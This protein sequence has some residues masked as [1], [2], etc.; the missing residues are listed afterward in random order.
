M[1]PDECQEAVELAVAAL[2][3]VGA[4]DWS[5]RAGTLEW[6]CWQ[7][8]DHVVDC[9]FSY[10]LQIAARAEAGFLP[11]QELHAEPE[12]RPDDLIAALR[13]TTTMF[14]AVVRTSPPHTRASDGVAMLSL[15]DWCARASHEVLVHTHDTVSTFDRA[16]VVPDHLCRA[17]WSCEA[18]WMLDRHASPPRCPPWPALL[19]ASGR[20]HPVPPAA[21]DRPGTSGT[22]PQD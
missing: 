11:F 3:G 14:L 2:A 21:S 6:S 1:T 9:V 20:P 7:T 15:S 10:V 17:I 18:V 12:A 13:A 8:V 5:R 22:G 19:V 16:L 4:E